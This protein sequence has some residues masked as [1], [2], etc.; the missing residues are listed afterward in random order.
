M[1][2]DIDSK[3]KDCQ[4]LF[5]LEPLN[6]NTRIQ[7]NI[8]TSLT[9]IGP[10]KSI[11]GNIELIPNNK[12]SFSFRIINSLT[13]KI[14]VVKKE[15]LEE[16][17]KVPNNKNVFSDFKEGFAIFSNG[18]SRNGSKNDLNSQKFCR[19]FCVGDIIS[20][21]FDG[22]NG[23]LEFFLNGKYCGCFLEQTFTQDIYIPAV[24]LQGDNEK[25]MLTFFD[26]N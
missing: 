24:A 5:K 9:S 18:N 8:I 17:K 10:Y 23:G 11:Y 12:Y 25:L 3:L 2:E 22:I 26:N 15:K 4:I 21:F 14:G 6:D 1:M 7:N 19:G 16:I 13:C 20:V